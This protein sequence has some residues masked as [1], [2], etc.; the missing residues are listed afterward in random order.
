VPDKDWKVTLEYV[1]SGTS[2]LEDTTFCVREHVSDPAGN[3]DGDTVAGDLA[4][5]LGTTARAMAPTNVNLSQ[6]RVFRG[7]PYG[8]GEGDP[9][10]A[11]TSIVN[12]AGTGPAVTGGLPHGV[13]C[14][15]SV[16]TALASRRGRGRFHAPSPCAQTQ[17]N[18]S[19]HWGTALPH[20]IAVKAFADNLLAGHDVTHDLIVHHYSL[21]VH[22]RADATTRDATKVLPRTEVSYLRS[23]LTS[24]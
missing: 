22:S 12:L 3:L 17:L 21:R 8:P 23:R 13:C 18:D 2:R 7:G 16:Y 19:D 5:W 10:E 1:E 9:Q 20:Y 24:P 14:R 6:V 4:S 15:V 11:G